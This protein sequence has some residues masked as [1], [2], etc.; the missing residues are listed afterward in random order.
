MNEKDKSPGGGEIEGKR[1]EIGRKRRR[2]GWKV[3]ECGNWH[4]IVL[5]RKGRGGKVHKH[6][7]ST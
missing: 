6:I 4:A 1:R 5:S 2:R 3:K 7:T